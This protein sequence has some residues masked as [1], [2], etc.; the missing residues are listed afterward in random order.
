MDQ[1]A[2][3]KQLKYTLHQYGITLEDPTPCLDAH[4]LYQL[5]MSL[6]RAMS[7]LVRNTSLTLDDVVRI[8]RGQT[9]VDP[10]PSKDLFQI[11][12]SWSEHAERWNNVV[13]DGVNLKLLREP[14]D[15]IT[16]PRNHPSVRSNLNLIVK[17][18]RE[19]QDDLKYLILDIDTLRILNERQPNDKKIKCY[20]IGAVPKPGFEMDE[21]IRQI[22]DFSFPC[23]DSLNDCLDRKAFFPVT[24]EGPRVIMENAQTKQDAHTAIPIRGA[25]TDVAGAYRNIPIQSS[26]TRLQGAT[27]REYSTPV[28]SIDLYAS[29]GN[30]SSGY[31]YGLPAQIM[32][33]L[34]NGSESQWRHQSHNIFDSFTSTTWADDST[35]LEFNADARLM[36]SLVS[37][38]RIITRI[39]GPNAIAS[40]KDSGWFA[41]G[42]SLGLLFNF[43]T[44]ELSMKPDKIAK[45]LFRINMALGMNRLSKT[46]GEQLIGSLR[47]VGLVVQTAKAF[48]QRLHRFV[49]SIKRGM[50]KH[51]TTDIIDDLNWL[52]LVLQH[53][54]LNKIPFSQLTRSTHADIEC[55]MDASGSGSCTADLTNSWAFVHTHSPEDQALFGDTKG[56]STDALGINVLELSST[57]HAALLWAPL[58]SQPDRQV[59]INFQLDNTSAIAWL[60]K[61]YSPN[62]RGQHIV[63][64]LALI[65]VIYNLR[66]TATFIPGVENILADAGS[67]LDEPSKQK[68]FSELTNSFQVRVLPSNFGNVSML[69]S[70]FFPTKPGQQVPTINTADIG[71]N[72]PDGVPSMDIGLSCQGTPNAIR[73]NLPN[74]QH[75]CGVSGLIDFIMETQLELSWE[76][77]LP[78][79]RCTR[80]SIQKSWNYHPSSLLSKVLPDYPNL[81]PSDC[82]LTWKSCDGSLT[83]S[84]GIALEN[85]V[86]GARSS[87][88]ISSCSDD[89][90]SSLPDHQGIGLC[91]DDA[92]SDFGTTRCE[93]ANPW[94][95]PVSPYF[96]EEQRLINTHQVWKDLCLNQEIPPS[97][98]LLLPEYCALSTTQDLIQKKDQFHLDLEQ[99]CKQEPQQHGLRQRQANVDATQKDMDF[100]PLELAELQHYSTQKKTHCVSNYLADGNPI[101]M[102][103]TQEWDLTQQE[104]CLKKWSISSGEHD[105]GTI[106]AVPTTRPHPGFCVEFKYNSFIPQT[107]QVPNMKLPVIQLRACDRSET[108]VSRVTEKIPP[109]KSIFDWSLRNRSF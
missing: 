47:Y 93:N 29:F 55:V 101:A 33:D 30:A 42:P 14:P 108:E 49:V 109:E 106:G 22:N 13:R 15:Q 94:K 100:T 75:T 56:N 60:N 4:G 107:L 53:G 10:R 9:A 17:N 73:N 62:S 105:S 51:I 68:I 97:V 58:W 37:Q 1:T 63:R 46:F 18:Y 72:G 25:T 54:Q 52:R 28:W 21:K 23:G 19:G 87:S 76:K 67:R 80:S 84:T 12:P 89:Q 32:H 7:K 77:Y 102:K 61:K 70:R 65:E 39:L 91:F 86:I 35:L 45:A 5:D 104:E 69:W 71:I 6:C 98:P 99:K 96:S 82:Q 59:H 3:L 36:E 81:N 2:R 66:F 38:Y 90:K 78:F 40:D 34:H 88:L 27:L 103:A 64:L 79:V 57:L 24:F 92:I 95:H 41:H 85:D 44:F 11:D 16:P 20:P 50:S 8:Y 74:M 48:F 83:T 26:S 43:T 31:D